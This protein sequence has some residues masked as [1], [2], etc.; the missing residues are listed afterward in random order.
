MFWRK[1]ADK[2][3]IGIVI[4]KECNALWCEKKAKK[5]PMERQTGKF[6]KTRLEFMEKNLKMNNL[7]RYRRSV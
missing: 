1:K 2:E 4:D 6:N 5:E 3:K 7:G